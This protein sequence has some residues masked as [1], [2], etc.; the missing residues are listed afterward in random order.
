MRAILA[1]LPDHYRIAL[2]LAYMEGFPTKELAH[3]LNVP[4]GTV[5]ARLH[6]G[7]KLF[8]KRMWEYAETHGLLKEPVR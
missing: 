6:R 2:V 3:M 5:L 4:L 7:R 1:S 8:E